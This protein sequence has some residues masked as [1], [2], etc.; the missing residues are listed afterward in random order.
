MARRSGKFY[1]KNEKEVMKMFGLNPTQGSGSGWIEKEDG[2]N[3][4]VIVQLKSTDKQSMSIKKLDLDKLVY[5][6]L[7]CKKL[8]VFMI[9]FLQSEDVYLMIKP[10]D[11]VSVAKYIET[12]KVELDPFDIE[13]SDET[14]QQ[15]PNKII[16][17]S[18][19]SR[20]KFFDEEAK[21]WQKRR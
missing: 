19:K 15:K 14:P 4:N 2:Q 12:G 8:P 21:K 6:A 5:N 20:E 3:D 10:Q 1:F 13:L 18:K 9:Q 11:L 17:N 16:K 7:V